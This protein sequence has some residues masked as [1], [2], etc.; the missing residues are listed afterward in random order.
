[1]IRYAAIYATCIYT[2]DCV[3]LLY[4]HAQQLLSI[5]ESTEL[6]VSW[7]SSRLDNATTVLYCT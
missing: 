5:E 2:V 7:K 1:M 4:N 6:T 3:R